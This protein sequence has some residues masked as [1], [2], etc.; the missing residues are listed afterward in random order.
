MSDTVL[1]PGTET[2]GCCGGLEESTPRGVDN[3]HGLGTIAYRIGEY[4]QF[5]ASMLAGLSSSTRTTSRSASSTRW[6]APR[7]C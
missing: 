7:T 4:A 5:K 1:P 3:R 2:C 6:R